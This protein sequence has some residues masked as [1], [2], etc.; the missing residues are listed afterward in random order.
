MAGAMGHFTYTSDDGVSYRIKSDVSNAAPASVACVSNP[1]RPN[2]PDGYFTRHAW[3]IDDADT[4]GGRTPTRRRRKIPICTVAGTAYTGV[5]TSISL[6][7]FSVTPS[8]AVLWTIQG[9]VGERRL[10]R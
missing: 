1:G 2:L 5:A 8:V 9:L 4:T 7:D 6:P 10:V 3:V